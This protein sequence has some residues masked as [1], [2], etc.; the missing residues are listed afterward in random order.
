MIHALHEIL[1]LLPCLG[2]WAAKVLEARKVGWA[3]AMTE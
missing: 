1:W 3:M 2:I